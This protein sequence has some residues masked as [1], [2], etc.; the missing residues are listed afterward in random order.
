VWDPSLARGFD[1]YDGMVF[2]VFD[3]NPENKRAMFGGGRYNGLASIFGGNSFPAVGFAPGDETTKLFL[4]GW[5]LLDENK[6]KTPNQKVYLPLLDSSLQEEINSIAKRLRKEYKD[7][8]IGL[9]VQKMGKA[10][11]YANKGSFDFV[12]IFNTEEK[13][14]NIYLLKDMKSGEQGSIEFSAVS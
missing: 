6:I 13:E 3:K 12:A 11:E 10:L 5:N 8:E 14:K 7:V 1:Y 4:E 2:E 9:E